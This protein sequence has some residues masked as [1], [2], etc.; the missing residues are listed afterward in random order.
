[1]GACLWDLCLEEE[2][3]GQ[4]LLSRFRRTTRAFKQPH[5]Y[6]IY[7]ILSSGSFAAACLQAITKGVLDPRLPWADTCARQASA[8]R[9]PSSRIE[10]GEGA[11]APRSSTDSTEQWV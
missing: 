10:D 2:A 8:T 11:V 6:V 7:Y 3:L 4:V 9:R 1:M 5:F